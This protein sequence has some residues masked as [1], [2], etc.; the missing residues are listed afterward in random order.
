MDLH[1]FTDYYQIRSNL[2]MLSLEM[3]CTKHV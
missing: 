1:E 3:A 2:E